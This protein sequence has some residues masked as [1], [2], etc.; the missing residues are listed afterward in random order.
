[1]DSHRPRDEAQFLWARDAF[2]NAEGRPDIDVRELPA[3]PGVGEYGA[4]WAA[5]ICGDRVAAGTGRLALA[6][7]TASIEAWG[8]PIRIVVYLQVPVDVPVARDE[9][10]DAVAWSWLVDALDAYAPDSSAL[11]GSVSKIFNAGFGTLS[12][13]PAGAL[14]ELRAS[15][16]PPLAQVGG[17][18]AAWTQ[19]LALFA[20][21]PPVAGPDD[22]VTVLPDRQAPRA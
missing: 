9:L 18:R 11:A 4:A 14:L 7:D 3:C 2:R 16:T 10:L 5:Q 15:W 13:Q 20:G 17:C 19:A 8:G 22:Q 6:Y 1:M 21:L 12:H